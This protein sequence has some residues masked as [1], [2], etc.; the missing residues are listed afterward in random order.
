VRHIE[1]RR[2]QIVETHDVKCHFLL[3]QALLWGGLKKTFT[4]IAY[5]HGYTRTSVKVLLY[6]QLDRWSLRRPDRIVTLCKPFAQQL[7]SKGI[8]IEKISILSNAVQSA[9][10]VSSAKVDGLRKDL[11]IAPD[12]LVVLSVGR[13]SAE[14][15]HADL[16]R[17]VAMSVKLH[18]ELRLRLVLVG[19]GP[20][21][22]QLQVLAAELMC[23]VTFAGH[24]SDVFVY[25]RLCAVFVLPSH[26]EGSPLVLLEAM[27]VAKP[28]VATAV[29]GVPEMI[30]DGTSGLLVEPGKP[31]ELAE[32]LF[33]VLTDRTLA[34]TI[35]NNALAR[36]VARS[37]ESYARDVFDIYAKAR[38]KIANGSP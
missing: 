30:E 33:R 15:G 5:H 25:Y 23:P 12:E 17:A 24:Q 18:P 10:E 1:A 3:A 27:S 11:N 38:R 34:D 28:I 14:K 9:P 7:V 31:I 29:G 2:P 35:G 21:K 6:Q 19:D 20:E 16:I 22:P 36:S 37:P 13:L 8:A 4:W 26:S 32:C